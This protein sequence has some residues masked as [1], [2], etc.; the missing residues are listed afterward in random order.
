MVRRVTQRDWKDDRIDELEKLLKAALER[1]ADSCPESVCR[2]AHA[3]V[4]FS[5]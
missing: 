5:S 1:I 4:P 2:L 3:K